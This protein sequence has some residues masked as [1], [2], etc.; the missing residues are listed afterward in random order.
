[1]RYTKKLLWPLV[2]VLAMVFSTGPA[3]AQQQLTAVVT[4]GALNVREGPGLGYPVETIVFEDEEVDVLGRDSATVYIDVRTDDGIVGWAG[5][6]FLDPVQD[7][8]FFELTVTAD[9]QP[10]AYVSTGALNVR[11][12]PGFDYSV[13]AVVVYG[14]GMNLLG[15]NATAE[16][17]YAEFASGLEGWVG[18]GGIVSNANL[19]NLP[20]VDLEGNPP[21]DDDPTATPNTHTPTNTPVLTATLPGP[22]DDT[23]VVT[24]AALNV[25]SGPGVGYSILTAVGRGTELEMIGRSLDN[26]WTQVELDSGLIGWVSTFYIEFDAQAFADLPVTDETAPY[27]VIDTGALNLR[28]GPDTDEDIIDFYYEGTLVV[29][30]GRNSDASWLYVETPDNERGWMSSFY[31]ATEYPLLSLPVE[32]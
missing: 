1:M 21:D 30:L 17:A 29:L 20:I 12:G 6:N 3:L 16:W 27:G 13:I 2:V 15:R 19:F 14:E 8:E 9:F 26:E 24:A 18:T 25:R 23:A 4:T 10:Q 22:T 28:E 7:Y 5:A 32:D 11:T 31:I